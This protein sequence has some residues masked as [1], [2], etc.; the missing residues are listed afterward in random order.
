MRTLLDDRGKI[1][2]EGVVRRAD[3]RSNR[4]CGVAPLSIDQ[5]HDTAIFSPV[6]VEQCGSRWNRSSA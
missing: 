6:I 3:A 2:N 4:A 5:S 1:E